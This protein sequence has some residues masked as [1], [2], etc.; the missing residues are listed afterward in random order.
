MYRWI[1]PY[2]Y[3][4]KTRVN[5][6]QTKSKK[7]S[8]TSRCSTRWSRMLQQQYQ[9]VLPNEI[10]PLAINEAMEPWKSEKADVRMCPSVPCVTT[11]DNQ[12]DIVRMAFSLS[13]VEEQN[14]SEAWIHVYTDRSATNAVTSGD[15][16]IQIQFPERDTITA[17]VA[18]EKY[19]SNYRAETEAFLPATSII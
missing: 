16:G 14:P 12:D 7:V 8:P 15:A 3:N 17:S 9:Q 13:M 10:L 2:L 11:K 5:V 1:L 6:D 19:C 4:H 18:T